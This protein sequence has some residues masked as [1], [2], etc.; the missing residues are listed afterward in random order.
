VQ[1][2]NCGS[3]IELDEGWLL[4]THGLARFANIPSAPFCWTRT[5]RQKSGA[6]ARASGPARTLRAGRLCPKCG[7]YLR[8]LTPCRANHPALCRFG[9]I[10]PFRNH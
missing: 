3:P 7:L 1:I 6:I 8:R 5:I 2:G 4:L 9:H 10:F